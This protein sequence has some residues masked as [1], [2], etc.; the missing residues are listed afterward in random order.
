MSVEVSDEVGESRVVCFMGFVHI[1]MT[2]NNVGWKLLAGSGWDQMFSSAKVFTFGVGT[3]LSGGSHVKHTRYSYQLT[4]AW[5]HVLKVKA[6][7]EYC[8]ADYGPHEP[9]ER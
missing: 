2:S 5:L 1:K 8:Q 6:Y 9:M 4:L 7:N 3:S